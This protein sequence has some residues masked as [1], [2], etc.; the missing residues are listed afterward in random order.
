VQAAEDRMRVRPVPG[1]APGIRR[2]HVAVDAS[3]ASGKAPADMTD[4]APVRFAKADTST[5]RGLLE[6]LTRS[7]LCF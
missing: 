4:A 5:A 1:Q 7:I 3:V 2:W 6:A